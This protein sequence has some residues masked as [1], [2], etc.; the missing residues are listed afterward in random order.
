MSGLQADHRR[1]AWPSP[2]LLCITGHNE[3]GKVQTK[4]D[5]WTCVVFCLQAV[6]IFSISSHIFMLPMPVAHAFSKSFLSLCQCGIV[7][8]SGKNN[9]ENGIMSP[10]NSASA[11]AREQH[12]SWAWHQTLWHC[13]FLY[14]T[15][16]T[17]VLWNTD[18]GLALQ[19][20][21]S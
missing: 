16:V 7:H 8:F 12:V 14:C 18:L 21:Y 19:N 17:I 11:G 15:E 2:S 3:H 20:W 13:Q 10:A 9:G 1:V 6:P 5:P 4:G